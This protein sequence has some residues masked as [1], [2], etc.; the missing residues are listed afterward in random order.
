MYQ[1]LGLKKRCHL[2]SLV[3][4]LI[5]LAV[6]QRPLLADTHL[7]AGAVTGGCG[8]RWSPPPGPREGLRVQWSELTQEP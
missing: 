4:F 5:F 6:R 7:P 3:R 2:V 8:S 1:E